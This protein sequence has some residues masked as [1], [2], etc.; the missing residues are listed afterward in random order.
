MSS[1][2]A[3][4][5]GHRWDAPADDTGTLLSDP[6][7]CPMCGT[8]AECA[9]RAALTDVP[10]A[11]RATLPPQPLL[12]QPTLP[13]PSPEATATLAPQTPGTPS[14]D[15]RAPVGYAIDRELGR[16]GMGVVYLARELVLK[17]PCALK[18]ILAGV[19][20]TS[21]EI[22][23]FRTE[24][25]AIARLQHPGIVQVFG[26]GEHDG[27]PF[28]A[29]EYC[30]GGS[31][32]T[33]LAKNPLAPKQAAVLVKALAEAVHVAHQAN[34]IHRDLK[35]A[36]VLLTEKGE[37]KVTD[38][39]LA[40]KLDE[41]GATRT[42]N[43]MGTP[44][45]MPPEQAEGKKD[46][47]PTADVYALG[48]I[49]YECLAFRPPFRAATAFD[50]IMQLLTQE[51]LPVRQL[52]AQAPVDLETI[53][54]KCLQKDPKKRYA[55]AQE[56]ADDLDC[57]LKGEPIRARPVGVVERGVKWVRR[58]A[59]VSTLAMAVLLV[60]IAGVV[61][62][63]W[64]AIKAGEEGKEAS[65]Q[66]QAARTA[67]KNADD[68]A[69]A[70]RTAEREA[71]TR[72]KAET[73]AKKRAEDEKNRADDK[74]SVAQHEKKRAEEQLGRAE[75]LVYAGKLS[76]AQRAFAEGKIDLALLYL[77]EC[78]WNLRGW[79]HR[80]LWTRCNARQTLLGHSGAVT[81]V[82]FSPDGRCIVTGSEDQTA[83]VWDAEKGQERISLKG[84]TQPVWCVAF[85]PDGKRLLTGSG[86]PDF[87]KREKSGEAKLWDADKGL[88]IR[89][90]KG[91]TDRIT[92]VAF[93]PDGKRLLT[94]SYDQTAKVWDAETG[95]EIRSLTGHT[96]YLS[97]VA[98]SPDGRCIVTGSWDGTAKVWDT[99]MGKEILSF[100]G[101]TGG[102]RSVAFSPDGK[103]LLTGSFDNSAKVW[104]TETGQELNS[105]KRHSGL[106]TSV[107]FSPDG[108][109]VLTGSGGYDPQIRPLPGEVTVWDAATGQEIRSFKGHTN[110]IFS[111]AF[112]PEGKR[113]LTGSADKTA[114]V[115][116]AEKG[117]DVLSLNG[118]S[119][120][121]TFSPDGK[122]ILTGSNDSPAKVW[123][124]ETGQ[125]ILSLKGHTQ[126]VWCVA[127]SPDGKR[128]VTGSGGY[129]NRGG[130]LPGEVKV[131]DAE[132]GQ[133]VFSLK[134]HTQAVPSVAFSPDGKQIVTGSRD[135]TAK[136]W[137]A[138]KGQEVRS[139]HVGGNGVTSVAFSPDGKHLLTGSLEG[140]VSV[141]DAENGQKILVL[142]AHTEPVWC[143]AFSPDGKRLLTGSYDQ[144]AKVW[145][146]E[147][148]R[149]VLSFKGH[150]DEIRTVAFSPDGQ[151]I[152]TGSKDQTAKMWDA[153]KGQ[154]VL[155]LSGHTRPVW[156]VAFSPNGKR[157]LTGSLDGT[158]KV[159]EAEQS[160]EILFLKGHTSAVT[161]MAFS[162][163]G[164]RLLTGSHDLTV[165]VWD[166]EKG[167]EVFSL[168]GHADS[169]T[170]VAF[171]SDGQRVFAWDFRQKVLA[172]S[173][174]DGQPVEPDNPP[175]A[176][177]PGP[178]VAHNGGL[179]AEPWGIYIAVFDSRRVAQNNL[180]PLPDPAERRRYH[181]QQA[182][183]A[184]KDKQW[185][186]VAFHLGRLLLDTPDDADLKRRR[187][188]SLRRHADARVVPVGPHTMDKVP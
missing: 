77:E 39:G 70:A 32:D 76:L 161:S 124:A 164:K 116:D 174:R 87:L 14:L 151:R 142:A 137:D 73:A 46:I 119:G 25:Q 173:L 97:S 17:R 93:S 41:Q 186:A 74:T 89:S 165:K 120:P 20:S 98:F 168:R 153:Q 112:S 96:A 86:V 94:G 108:K 105:F 66:A 82:A 181:T 141:W 81:S 63:G 155:S 104:D 71:E 5:L 156:C 64:F 171:S 50:T 113:I 166:V 65:R 157:L 56:L 159:W 42:G 138:E 27:K 136:V 18:M 170:N 154:E 131:W 54:A 185:F 177:P 15:P 114:K 3:C 60:L 85:S 176:P 33:R 26:I 187:E 111:V 110:S 178:A 59:L 130:P 2:F 122:R 143:V 55:T 23:R 1:F 167:Q 40:K 146:A 19:H 139:L 44:S 102:V 100:K 175:T 90:L 158:T 118:T 125:A 11:D 8:P 172:W 91:H 135:L 80:H 51:P 49:L 79:E 69:R 179:R 150:T 162:P 53:C 24:A 58:N 152:V 144:T 106:V 62:S 7:V 127:F 4:P 30:S 107:A 38:F 83:K 12:E 75:W 140:T 29:L 52:N 147:T 47:G 67:E 134:G 117:Q 78:Q 10:P 34:V 45:Y 13:P 128:I 169:V 132:K 43:I 6:V 35:P 99:N 184:E 37:P 92:S 22:E 68:E 149:L 101:H 57:Y 9:T 145:D 88:E 123:D 163:D 48:A 182:A 31:L 72:A 160:Q 21:S 109:H 183:L 126:P 148:G 121:V 95:Q 16:G 36:N 129:D 28:M 188:E 180:W 84:H 103:R 115:W 133:E 61:V